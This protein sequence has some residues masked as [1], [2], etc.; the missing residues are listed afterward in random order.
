MLEVLEPGREGNCELCATVREGDDELLYT[1][2][3]G[4]SRKSTW[5]PIEVAVVRQEYDGVRFRRSDSPFLGSHAL[6]FRPAVLDFIGHV[7][8]EYGELL[9][10]SCA[11]AELFVFNPTRVV[12]ALN[13]ETSTLSRFCDGRIMMIDRHEFRPEAIAGID[14]FK[15]PQLRVSPTFVSSRIAEAW[16]IARLR[17]LVFRKV[18]EAP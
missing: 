12:D 5:T 1:L 4:E 6:I 13:E 11:D 18:W 17:G 9:P 8:E 2:I 3:N 14:I 16:K 10:L 15:I 7:F